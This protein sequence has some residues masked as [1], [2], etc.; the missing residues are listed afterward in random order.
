MGLCNAQKGFSY[1]QE[2]EVRMESAQSGKYLLVTF[3]SLEA[4]WLTVGLREGAAYARKAYIG[5]G[6]G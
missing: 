2:L 6:E 4:C 3:L 1:S 5:R